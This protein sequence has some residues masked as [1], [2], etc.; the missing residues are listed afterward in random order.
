MI[1]DAAESQLQFSTY[2]DS[3]AL[4]TLNAPTP[5]S[6]ISLRG[7]M[8]NQWQWDELGISGNL[9]GQVILNAALPRE[10]KLLFDAN[11]DAVYALSAALVIRGQIKRFQKALYAGAGSYA[12]TD[13][14]TFVRFSSVP[15]YSLWLGYRTRRKSLEA[16]QRLRFTEDNLEMR[17]RYRLSTRSIIEGTLTGSR[18]IHRD[19]NAVAVAE[20]TLLIPLAYA[21]DDRGLDGWLHVRR[22]GRT[23]V[24]LQF[25]GGTVR[26][27]SVIGA[28]IIVSARAYISGQLRPATFYHI[29]LRLINKTYAFPSLQ[30]ESRY[31]DPEEPLQNMAHFRLEQALGGRGIGYLQVS[32]LQN[33]TSINQRYYDKTMVEIGVKLDL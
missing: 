10:S 8:N 30:G 23:I 18:V 7:R 15:G 33:E 27:N 26:S 20:D 9:M 14:E 16:S 3:N 2:F 28:F 12:W 5:S 22:G 32:R 21:Q 24:G 29:D 4:E 1:L 19:F 25:G 17:A 13:A 11:L 6:G 31:R